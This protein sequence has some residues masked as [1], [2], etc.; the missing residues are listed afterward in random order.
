M[1]FFPRL[2]NLKLRPKGR[3]S[4]EN[5]L[6]SMLLVG[7]LI[8]IIW[9]FWTRTEQR[10]LK[11]LGIVPVLDQ[12]GLL[13]KEQVETLE[14]LSGLFREKYNIN[15]KVLIETGSDPLPDRR[16]DA[17]T[18]FIDLN[19]QTSSSRILLPPLVAAALPPGFAAELKEEFF[20]APF[21]DNLPDNLVKASYKILEALMNLDRPP[22]NGQENSSK[23]DP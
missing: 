11:E 15:F 2:S 19:R 5:F 22:A 7:L 23:A 13:S 18:I 4:G 12:S 21:D 9:L 10:M 1:V 8:L 6:R 20:P 3:S 14:N 17:S 16:P